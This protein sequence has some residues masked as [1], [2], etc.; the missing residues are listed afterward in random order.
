[1]ETAS[2]R[3]TPCCLCRRPSVTPTCGSPVSAV[4]RNGTSERGIGIPSWST[5]DHSSSSIRF[6]STSAGSTP[7]MRDALGLAATNFPCRSIITTPSSSDSTSVRN[8]SRSRAD[9]RHVARHTSDSAPMNAECTSAHFHGE[10]A[11]S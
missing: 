2:Q 9:A 11:S 7:R 4:E 8:A 5:T 10:L 6:A 1:M 3:V